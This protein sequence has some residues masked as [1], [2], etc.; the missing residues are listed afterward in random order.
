MLAYYRFCVKLVSTVH[1]ILIFGNLLAVPFLVT[2]TPFYIWMP[3]ITMLV[4]PV[5]G[6][7]Y[8]SF[9]RLE[10]HF[11]RKAGMPEIHD[12]MATLLYGTYKQN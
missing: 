8:C 12:R 2:Q 9:N 10:N 4:S 7:A 5:L 6:G 11:R 3:M 1:L